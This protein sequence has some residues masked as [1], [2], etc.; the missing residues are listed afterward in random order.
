MN[1]P[2]Q[3]SEKY[4]VDILKQKLK[5]LDR[6]VDLIIGVGK[7]GL[8]PAVYAAYYLEVPLTHMGL[9]SYDKHTQTYHAEITQHPVVDHSIHRRI[10]VIDDVNDSGFTFAYINNYMNNILGIPKEDIT[11]LS[12][13]GKHKTTF[14][15]EVCEYVPDDQWIVF[16]WD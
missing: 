2:L 13:Y 14:K 3:V 6:D 7:G 5:T 8:V 12:V 15:S 10:L 4:L 1:E 16:P 11:F 9:K